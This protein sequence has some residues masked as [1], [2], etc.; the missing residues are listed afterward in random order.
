ML[1][2]ISNPKIEILAFVS[3]KP[4]FVQATES[5][6]GSGRVSGY[7]KIRMQDNGVPGYQGQI[8]TKC[9]ILIA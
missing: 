4:D 5:N 7:Q 8:K 1:R 2:Q 6:H 9:V 3:P